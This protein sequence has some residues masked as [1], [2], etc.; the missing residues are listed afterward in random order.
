MR[1]FISIPEE[2]R[3]Y[4]RWVCWTME[5]RN[6]KPTKVPKNP[7]T[8]GNAMPNNPNTWGNFKQAVDRAKADNLPGIGFMFNGDGITGIDIDSCR[9]KETGEITEQAADIINTLDS[10]TEIS[11]SGK[12][13]HIICRGK[14]PEGK[15]R[16]KNVEMYEVG[17]YFVMT[18]QVI[19]DRGTIQDR[20]DQLAIVHKK[21]INV[22]KTKKNVSK[23]TEIVHDLDDDEIIQ[24][25]MA[26]KNGDL[27]TDLMNG[28]WKHRYQSQSE[29]DISLCNL[30]AFWTGRDA[31]KMNRIFRRSGLYRDK[32]DE[33]RP[34]GTYGSMTILNSIS[35]CNEIYVPK[36]EHKKHKKVPEPVAPEDNEESF[37][38]LVRD[39]E[40]EQKI[41]PK[42]GA[43]VTEED[44]RY[45]KYSKHGLKPI[46]NF[47]IT[48]IELVTSQRI[49]EL[50][51]IIET[52]ER[53]KTH[54]I[55]TMED[56]NTTLRFRKALNDI[57]LSFT[58]KDEDLQIIKSNVAQKDYIKKTGVTLSGF[59]S[60]DNRIYFVTE[61]QAINIK[62]QFVSDIVLMETSRE[63]DSF[64]LTVN[65]I[66]RDELKLIA[67]SLFKFNSIGKT[68]TIVG[69]VA[70]VFL[71]ELLWYQGIKFCHLMIIG[72]RGSGK[73]ETV[74][75]ILKQ[76]LC[77]KNSSLAAS[78]ITPFVMYKNM[79][80]SNFVPMILEEYKPGIIGVQ[81]AKEI[82]NVL[83][84]S[85]D[86][87]TIQ[88]GTIDQNI[89]SYPLNAPVILVGESGIHEA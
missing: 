40:K 48:P 36:G 72:E 33:A 74:E 37:E 85:Y 79:A 58:G 78:S 61:S 5:D 47:I 73:S 18:G 77:S 31:D 81:K 23:N 39:H 46:S 3:K 53:Y 34:G 15:R 13:I 10:Y 44:Y 69:Y 64:I 70:A 7:N 11:A 25:A 21:Y 65:S 41:I 84:D 45:L 35:N 54:R 8:G 49:S 12:G 63:L 43:G 32:W 9:D 17:R 19:D 1:H 80:S 38:Q 71:K 86:R 56:F 26:A 42:F 51:C 29:A 6:G 22:Q 52:P 2:L 62:S 67:P 50:G 87:H 27:F 55:F 57:N 20:T 68:A 66:T 82:S 59:H 83:R 16:H 89:L 88:R 14:L 30:L 24:K 4:N 76:I 28:N 75:N 60:V